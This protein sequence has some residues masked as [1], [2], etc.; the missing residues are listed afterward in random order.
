MS[1]RGPELLYLFTTS[2][3]VVLLTN[4]GLLLVNI[5]TADN[6]LQPTLLVFK[7]IKFSNVQVCIHL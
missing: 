4:T 3:S 7:V 5:L 1:S 2:T 6:V